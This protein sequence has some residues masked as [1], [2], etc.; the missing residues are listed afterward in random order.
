[1]EEF[2]SG[3]LGFSCPNEV[4]V[5]WDKNNEDRCAIVSWQYLK[6]KGRY[7]LCEVHFHETYDEEVPSG[8]SKSK[9]SSLIALLITMRCISAGR[10]AQRV[11][12][13][14][15]EKGNGQQKKDAQEETFSLG[16]DIS[17]DKVGGWCDPQKLV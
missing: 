13:I 7:I 17:I 2:S 9:R 11:E 16:G 1:M 5:S 3:K 12:Q 4:W 8:D 10:V 15:W 6:G 14:L